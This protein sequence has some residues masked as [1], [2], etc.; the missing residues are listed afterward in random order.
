M[1]KI[2]EQCQPVYKDGTTTGIMLIH[3]IGSCPHFWN[4]LMPQFND[5]PFALRNM[6]LPG[7]GSEPSTLKKVDWHE[8]FIHIKQNLFE[9]RKQCKRV[10]VI[11]F[12]LGAA[13]GLH[14][15]AHYQLEGLICLST[16]FLNRK[17][18]FFHQNI[19]ISDYIRD[20]TIKNT[21]HFYYEL[22]PKKFIRRINQFYKHVYDDLQDIYIPTLMIHGARNEAYSVN[23]AKL[24][25]EKIASPDKKI[26]ILEHSRHLI[27][28]GQEKA[29]VAREIASFLEKQAR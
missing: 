7:H 27:L 13:M 19:K 10:I 5:S 2:L 22:L 25:Y 26:L 1:E 3:G 18:Y 9:L 20:K 29:I 14:L 12:D 23:D 8:I 6:L 11:G 28:D 24:L 17:Y 16:A 4:A 15:S 21:P